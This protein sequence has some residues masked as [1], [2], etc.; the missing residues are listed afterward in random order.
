MSKNSALSQNTPNILGNPPIK[1]ADVL[2]PL[3]FD[4]CF[5][6]LLPEDSSVVI[7]QLVCAPFRTKLLV[8]V[9][10]KIYEVETSSKL[11][12]LEEIEPKHILSTSFIEFMHKVAAYNLI[13]MGLVFKMVGC[14]NSILKTSVRKNSLSVEV[15][16]EKIVSLTNEQIEAANHLA[17][18]LAKGYNV[19]LLDGITGSGKTEVYLDII[20]KV[21]SS[22][23][24]ALVLLPEI[25]LT[26][27]LTERF[28]ARFGFAPTEWHSALTPRVKRINWQKI[29]NGEA[30]FIVGARSAL[31][32]PYPKLKLIVVD[33]EHEPSF[34]Q[35][36]GTIYNARDMA[37]L[38]GKQENILTILC[39]A[40]P[41]I[42]TLY[43][44]Q[45]GKYST[46]R[47]DSRFGSASIPEIKIVDLNKYPLQRN[48]WISSPLQE[49]L[50]NSLAQKKQS[51]L[52]LNRR[53][54]APIT[55]CGD[56]KNKIACPNCNFYLVEHRKTKQLMCHYCGYHAAKLTKC[57]TCGSENKMYAV[58]PGVERIEEEVKNLFPNARVALLTSDTVHS[59]SQ[60][61]EIIGEIQRHNIDIIIGTQMI[62]KGLHFPKLDLVGVIDADSNVI[63]GDIRAIERTYQLLHQVAG[64]A[65]RESNQGL[66]MI[67]TFDPNN[68]YLQML[69]DAKRDQFFAAE[70]YDRKVANMPPFTRIA[71]ISII[72]KNEHKNIEFCQKMAKC[73][74]FFDALKVL[75]PSSAPIFYLRNQYRHR[76]V[77][78]A[79]KKINL[80]KIIKYWLLELPTP[81]GIK[82]KVDID[83]YAFV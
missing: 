6:Y 83:P 78:I 4:Q 45:I 71:I 14:T 47:L 70:L 35:D 64:R 69:K 33:E 15:A 56:C 17:S 68:V 1:V 25:V 22:G 8:G 27:Q 3:P 19:C 5:T 28:T 9:V 46:V 67:Q 2:L 42:E 54:Y 75:G 12:A 11:K 7:G 65:G 40:T 63:G 58:G 72:S 49:E 48:H 80:Q 79:E 61:Q 59:H 52:F 24:Q 18:L 50:A 13:P 10:I 73:A 29:I 30:K 39:S 23:D 53:G 74:P 20:Q 77:L 32:L 66:V 21:I 41:S 37:I 26:T 55:L 60:V 57:Q 38:K 44:V 82:V 34:K 43:N 51:L 16:P 76:F 31:F 36:E 81:N 62:T